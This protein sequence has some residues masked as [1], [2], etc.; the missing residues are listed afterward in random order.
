MKIK[1]SELRQ[2]VKSIIKEQSA[3]EP[4]PKIGTTV[5]IYDEDNPGSKNFTGSVCGYDGKY[6]IL[7]S[8]TKQKCV[9][10]LWQ[11]QYM[12]IRKIGNTYEVTKKD[13]LLFDRDCKTDCKS[14]PA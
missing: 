13:L 6:I 10:L 12:S 9:E 4:M 14:I 2:I 11:P 3:S 5:F 7:R 1:L 8:N